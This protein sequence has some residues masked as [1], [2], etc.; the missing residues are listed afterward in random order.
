MMRRRRIWLG[1]AVDFLLWSALSFDWLFSFQESTGDTP[2]TVIRVTILLLAVL[3]LAVV[4]DSLL[5]LADDDSAAMPT[6]FYLTSEVEKPEDL[7]K[8]DFYLSDDP[9][10]DEALDLTCACHVLPSLRWRTRRRPACA[11]R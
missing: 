3:G 6:H 9:K 5:K 11:C 7:E 2:A 4:D 10:A 1:L 8:A